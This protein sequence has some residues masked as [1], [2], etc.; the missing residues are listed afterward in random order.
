MFCKE[1]GKLLGSSDKF[2]PECG[3]KVTVERPKAAPLEPMFFV[4]K[5]EEPVVEK[6]PKK[7]VHHDEFNWD[8]AG[9]PTEKRKTEAVDFDWASVLEDKV[10][11]ASPKPVEVKPEPAVKEEPLGHMPKTV[12]ELL[13]ALPDNILEIVEEAVEEEPVVEEAVEEVESATDDL[14]EA[15]FDEEAF[16]E[17][18]AEDGTAEEVEIKSLEQIIEDFGA[19]PMD[20]P[21]RLIDKAQMKADSVDRFYVFSKKQAEYQNMLDQEYDKIQNSLQE[22][23]EGE[24]TPTVEEILAGTPV[25][26]PAT[27]TVGAVEEVETEVTEEEELT[28]AEVAVEEPAAEE[29]E[30]AVEEITVVPVAEVKELELVAIAW[31]MP[32]VG[33]V[34]ETPVE[35]APKTAGKDTLMQEQRVLMAELEK[36]MPEGVEADPVKEEPTEDVAVEAVEEL[37]AE[38]A[39][40]KDEELEEPEAPQKGTLTF[41]DIFNDEEDEDDE[42]KKGGGCL[43]FIAIVLIIL[44]IIELGILGIQHFAKDS[45]AAKMINQTYG[46][47]VNMISGTEEPE[48]PVEEVPAEPSELEL[49]ITAQKEKNTNIGEIVENNALVFE[50]DQDYG[51]EEL[52]DTYA[53][54]NSLWYEAED[55]K[56]VT[57][58]DEIIGTLIQYYSAL[59]DKINDVNKDVLDYVDNTTALYEELD[60]IEGDE[61]RGYAINRLE[62][63]EIKTGQKGFYAMVNIT[64]ADKLQ[65]EE[66]QQKQIVYLEA[67]PS[68]KVIKMKETKNI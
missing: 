34:V 53:F 52:A 54:K 45:E 57:Y 37:K 59:P 40:S 12:E 55:G 30:E 35:K 25:E 3:T 13:A 22:K 49:L 17:E 64:S 11:Q 21:T 68:E 23:E 5:R 60:Q 66:T 16:E 33:I 20:E 63:G 1:C 65:P 47:I 48:T 41:A 10:R 51:Y 4:E 18:E 50:A 46:K 28:V 27:D 43:K 14:A 29:A 56:D 67:N 26:E 15:A 58:G 24:P 38:P 42:V 9:F 62:I 31:S 2:C 7:V 44:V 61:T 32:P 8:L 19:G 39:P 36:L 6:K